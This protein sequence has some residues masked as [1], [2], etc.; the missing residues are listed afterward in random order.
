V[1]K[2]VSNSRWQK[3]NKTSAL[4]RGALIL[5]TA[6]A[7]VG[8]VEA[9]IIGAII[10]SSVALV[11]VIA[12]LIVFGWQ[13]RKDR[14]DTRRYET[15][16]ETAEKNRVEAQKI[17]EDNRVEA[18]DIAARERFEDADRSE[19]TKAYADFLVAESA[20]GDAFND[21]AAARNELSRIPFKRDTPEYETR[22]AEVNAQI[23]AASEAID[24]ARVAA[25]LPLSVMRL[26]ASDE[27][28]RA[29][30]AYDKA[31]AESNPR[32]SRV[33]TVFLPFE[34]KRDLIEAFVIASRANLSRDALNDRPLTSVDEPKS[35]TEH[36]GA[37]E[38]PAGGA[39]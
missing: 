28:M 21:Y 14:A 10:S 37:E 39:D 3:V 17:A 9:P 18:M 11:S 35:E 16:R 20:R 22:L 36:D 33:K 7:N 6:P 19:R 5:C 27:V 23:K 2:G 12:G 1:D 38:I 32:R 25:W 24:R 31:I 34:R 30:N 15:A 8:F 29:A 13:R 4:P 26:V